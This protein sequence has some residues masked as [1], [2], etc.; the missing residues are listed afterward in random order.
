MF[1]ST[2]TITSPRN[3]G[4]SSSDI[5]SQTHAPFG[6]MAMKQSVVTEDKDDREKD[7]MEIDRLRE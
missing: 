5:Y 3:S 7:R 2:I 6:S 1:S 4:M